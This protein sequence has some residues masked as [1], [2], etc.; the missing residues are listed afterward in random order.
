MGETFREQSASLTPVARMNGAAQEKYNDDS[1]MKMKLAY[2]ES[3]I[4]G[5]NFKAAKLLTE[6]T[7]LFR[8][9]IYSEKL[10]F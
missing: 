8:S 4:P 10:F 3:R 9:A 6:Q 5:Q 2:E 7:I 1:N